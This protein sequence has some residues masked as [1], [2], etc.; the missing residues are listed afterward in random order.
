M[1]EEIKIKGSV[2][3][4]NISGTKKILNQ[5]M[6]CICKIK[7]KGDNQEGII[8]KD[9]YGTG[10]FCAIPLDENNIINCLMTN[11]HVLN[12]KYF[13][14]KK[15]INILLNDDS[16]AKL[17]DLDIKR[18][19]HYNKEYDTTIIEL[20]EEDKIKNYLELDDNIFKDNENIFYEGKS[21]YII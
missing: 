1:Q 17:I 16:E 14:D 6:K 10:F 19:I 15:E 11:Y 9:A 4:V 18:I 20:K 5:M 13:E 21:I 2:D 7:I 3:P 8:S 12:E